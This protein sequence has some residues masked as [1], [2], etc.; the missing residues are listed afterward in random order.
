MPGG[1]DSTTPSWDAIADDWVMHADS[2]DY[3]NLFLVPRMLQMLGDVGGR[4]VLDLGCGEGRYSR[5]LARRGA[6][7]TGVDASAR[8]IEVARERARA[9]GAAVTYYHA[10]AN[11]L[12]VLA[13]ASH[14]VVLAAMSLMNVEDYPGAVQEV[15]RVLAPGGELVVSITHP[16]FSAPTSEWVRDAAAPRRVFAVDRYFDRMAWTEKIS[17]AFRAPV[18]RRHRTLEDYFGVL[19]GAGFE[20]KEF[21]EPMATEEEV[22]QSARFEH[23]TRIPYFLFMRWQ[24]SELSNTV[25]CAQQ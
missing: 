24:R 17:A 25:A 3:Q 22:G 16:C 18:V 21:L 10:N 11:A 14:N 13:E 4:R 7:V 9:E 8:L 23:M 15:R 2:S 12:G 1:D 5:E 6:R 20:L 19:L